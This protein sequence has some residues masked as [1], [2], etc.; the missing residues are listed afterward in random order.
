MI[1]GAALA[2]LI[3]LAGAAHAQGQ[4]GVVGD[5]SAALRSISPQDPPMRRLDLVAQ[6]VRENMA[7]PEIVTRIV[8]SHQTLFSEEQLAA[9]SRALIFK[10]AAEI[11]SA[12]GGYALDLNGNGNAQT[13]NG[14][15]LVPVVVTGPGIQ[16]R[17]GAELVVAQD[18]A[19]QYRI[20]DIRL[21]GRSMLAVQI[22]EFNALVQATNRDP[23]L[24]V[25]AVQG[26][27]DGALAG[28]E[29]APAP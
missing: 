11:L 7:G 5:F 3:A 28:L 19:G 17:V 22:E 13:R 27:V 10:F 25:E 12:S 29:P 23:A 9:L 18:T 14:Q 21:D 6:A 24:I 4:G 26:V 1:R 15:A 16:G 2:L 20:S 8:A